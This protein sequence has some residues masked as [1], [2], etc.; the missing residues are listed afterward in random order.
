MN[1]QE[2]LN[3][4]YTAYKGR[5]A[6]KTPAWGSDKANIAIAIANRKQREWAN[7]TQQKWNSLFDI[8]DIGA[9]SLGT[10]TY[11]APLNYTHPSDKALIKASDNLYEVKFTTPQ[12]REQGKIYIHGNNPKKMT[13]GGTYI[14]SGYDNAI[15]QLPAY[16]MP[17][18]IVESDDNIIVDDPNWLI[19]VTAA[20]LCRNDPSKDD[21]F[22]NLLGMANDLYAKMIKE[23]IAQGSP[24]GMTIPYD[25]PNIGGLEDEWGL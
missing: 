10:F 15:L 2:L 9:I 23:N 14:E 17:D 16:F 5:V 12:K 1:A 21:Q 3:E 11:N 13:F 4:I 24:E 18:N 25:M 6:T 20:E 8:V 19:C 7:D 22:A